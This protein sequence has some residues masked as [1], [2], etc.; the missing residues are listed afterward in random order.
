MSS[1]PYSF[2]VKLVYPEALFKCLAQGHK[3]HAWS[4]NPRH[5]DLTTR[6]KSDTHFG[7]NHMHQCVLALYTWYFPEFCGRNHRHTAW[8][9]FEPSTLCSSRAVPYQL[10][11]LN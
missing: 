5:D 10:D 2:H 4:V 8:V 7:F 11:S 3:C 6:T 9:G 1:Q